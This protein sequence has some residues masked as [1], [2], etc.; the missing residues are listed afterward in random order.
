MLAPFGEKIEKLPFVYAHCGRQACG[1]N[2]IYA[3][4]AAIVAPAEARRRFSSLVSYTAFG[5]GERYRSNLSREKLH[6]APPADEVREQIRCFLADAPFILTLNS[7]E[8]LAELAAFCGV[9]RCLDLNFAAEFLVPHLHSHAPRRLWSYIHGKDREQI[10]FSAAEQVQLSMDLFKHLTGRLLSDRQ[11]AAAPALRYFLEKSDS[12]FGTLLVQTARR[13]REF[14]GGLFDP[15]SRP[16]TGNWQAFLQRAAFPGAEPDEKPPCRSIP[17]DALAER[18]QQL[19]EHAPGFQFRPLQASFANS[20]AR[21]FNESGI[22]CLEAGTGT[23]KTQGYLIPALEFLYRNP[24]A[25]VIISTYTKNLQEQIFTR[26]I[27][28]ARKSCGLYADIPA[29]LL[30][31]KS[32]Y[33]CAQKLDDAYEEGDRGGRLLSWLYFLNSIFWYR[34]ADVEGIGDAV[35][36]V[37]DNDLFLSHVRDLVSARS[38]CTPKHLSCPAQA[39]AAQACSARLVVTNH[40]K[41]ALLEQ[42]PVLAGRFQHC[43]IDEANH[44]ESAVRNAHTLEAD[45]ADVAKAGGYLARSLQKIGRRAP[46]TLRTTVRDALGGIDR[47]QYE[48]DV[49]GDVLRRIDP[50]LR[51]MAEAVLPTV[52]PRYRQGRL[53]DHLQ[54]IQAALKTVRRGLEILLEEENRRVLKVALRTFRKMRA[55]LRLLTNYGDCLHQIGTCTA[56]ENSV[57]TYRLFKRRHVLAAAP[58]EVGGIIREN[59]YRKRDSVVFIAATLRFKERFDDFSE[60]VGLDEPLEGPCGRPRCVRFQSL[61]TCFSDDRLEIVVPDDAV[62]GR[63][64]NKAAWLDSVAARLPQLI[65]KNRGRTL[66]LF[67]SYSDLAVIARKIQPAMQAAALPLLVQQPGR[68]TVGLCD[69]FRSVKESVLLGVDTFWYGVDFKG[70]TLTQVIITRI[71]YPSPQDPVLLARRAMF[72][73][74][75]YWRRYHYDKD[76]KLRQG[77]GRL[78]R[79]ATDR[80]RVVI[81]DARYRGGR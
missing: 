33:V 75:R 1:G 80:G 61:P 55:E 31:G 65:R 14:F 46:A 79:S 13:Y 81:L 47:L 73:P 58:V 70:D 20:I 59:I 15:C 42:D 9:A 74:E 56:L 28:V 76:I 67:A 78:I 7:G 36:S 53:L 69:A 51:P 72:P 11:H 8:D 77:I 49:L 16:D 41:L 60:I 10:S 32:S 66:V 3:L 23:G 63:Y 21:A 25:R 22:L 38:G 43:I 2:R 5:A 71:P 18:F 39:A 35:R 40:H 37:L 44:F 50:S 34:Q 26:E 24:H 30:K 29:A 12:L 68:S 19:A 27:A 52:H 57:L 62:S 48:T 64:R 45:T 4:A 6:R 17:E 54:A